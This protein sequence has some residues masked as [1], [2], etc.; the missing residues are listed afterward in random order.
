MI[1]FTLELIQYLFVIQ[2]MKYDS[3][4]NAE[5][6]KIEATEFF[7]EIDAE[8]NSEGRGFSHYTVGAGINGTSG[9]SGASHATAGG[10]RDA[11]SSKTTYGSLY[12]PV[13]AGSRGGVGY[14][15]DLG[16]RGGGTMRIIVGHSF[17]L[18]GV[19][20]VDSDKAKANSG[21]LS[22]FSLKTHIKVFISM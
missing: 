16:A 14:T 2:D 22:Y 5:F 13:S 7:L 1:R 11:E 15:R 21:E 4:F 18:D 10:N 12:E 17:H 3:Q 9:G 20:N 19:I 6:F 8:I